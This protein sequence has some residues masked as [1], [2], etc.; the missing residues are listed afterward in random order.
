MVNKI[1]EIHNACLDNDIKKFNKLIKD[2]NFRVNVRDNIKFTPLMCAAHVGNLLMV[3]KLLKFKNIKINARSRNGKTALII[4]ATRGHVKIVKILFEYGANP[5]IK[6]FQQSKKAC[7][8]K[9]ALNV[10]LQCAHNNVSHYLK[11]KKTK[12]SGKYIHWK[13]K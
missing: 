13:T 4:A 10:S 3:K 12:K 11:K 2:K 7:K 1:H 8:P 6:Q 5:N 9:T